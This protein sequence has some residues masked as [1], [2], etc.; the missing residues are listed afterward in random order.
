MSEW[1]GVCLSVF[2]EFLVI[3]CCYCYCKNEL[4][5][6]IIE[7]VL[8]KKILLYFIWN[9][10][11]FV[12]NPFLQ[13][14]RIKMQAFVGCASHTQTHSRARTLTLLSVHVL[15]SKQASKLTTAVAIPNKKNCRF[16]P[17]VIRK[18][19]KICSFRLHQHGGV[20]MR[21]CGCVRV[22]EY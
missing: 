8:T 5:S 7:I 3:V 19:R 10:I 14:S 13:G 15:P 2:S 17:F 12:L 9:W 1:V 21:M 22:Y 4:N 20:S 16:K 11:F 18:K 6:I